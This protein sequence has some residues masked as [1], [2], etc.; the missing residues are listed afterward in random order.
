MSSYQRTQIYLDPE[1]H[2]KLLAEASAR[3]ESLAAL[4]RDIV[5]TH[6]DER[7][8]VSGARSF[9]AITGI[10]DLDAPA[11][12]VGNWDRTMDEAMQQRY[13]KKTGAGSRARSPS[14]RRPAPRRADG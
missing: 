5:R 13:R 10:V 6:L 14:K 2:R 4:L 1:H 12:L 7:G 9:D 11:D 8:G 3:G